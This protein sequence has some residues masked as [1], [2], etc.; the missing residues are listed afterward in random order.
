[1]PPHLKRV[2]NS[3]QQLHY[4]VKYW[5]Q[6][7]ACSWA[8]WQSSWK[9]NSPEFWRVAD[10]SCI[11][12]WN[13]YI[14]T[15]FTNSLYQFSIVFVIISRR[16]F[17]VISNNF[18]K[19]SKVMLTEEV[20]TFIEILYL[21]IGYGP[22]RVMREFPSERRKTFGLDKLTT[23]LLKKWTSRRSHGVA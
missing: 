7:I 22:L 10:N 5:C 2:T 6:K 3:K 12:K 16:F 15:S 21:I 18:I 8:V 4:L 9:I 1:M 14:T 20:K 23:K 13:L 11:L 19:I 17:F